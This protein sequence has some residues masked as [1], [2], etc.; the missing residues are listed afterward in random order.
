MTLSGAYLGYGVLDHCLSICTTKR[1]IQTMITAEPWLSGQCFQS[2]FCLYL[3]QEGL[4]TGDIEY[5]P[6]MCAVTVTLNS[7]PYQA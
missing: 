3:V 7:S 2:K 4:R 5:C 6:S 1:A